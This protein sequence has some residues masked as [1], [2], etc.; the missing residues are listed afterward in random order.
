MKHDLNRAIELVFCLGILA[1]VDFCE[2][3]EPTLAGSV[4][5]VE[6]CVGVW[7]DPASSESR[8]PARIR[9]QVLAAYDRAGS[10]GKR[11]GRRGLFEVHSPGTVLYQERTMGR[12]LVVLVLALALALAGVGGAA[13][14]ACDGGFEYASVNTGA[15]TGLTE[16]TFV[17]IASDCAVAHAPHECGCDPGCAGF[18]AVATGLAQGSVTEVSHAALAAGD[19]LCSS[20]QGSVLSGIRADVWPRGS[21]VGR[22]FTYAAPRGGGTRPTCD[23]AA[24]AQGATV[25][26]RRLSVTGAVVESTLVLAPYGVTEGSSSLRGVDAAVEVLGIE[27]DSP[28]LVSCYLAPDRTDAVTLLPLTGAPLFG[29][30]SGVAVAAQVLCGPNNVGNL[31][32]LLNPKLKRNQCAQAD[33]L[34]CVLNT[35]TALARVS[36]TGNQYRGPPIQLRSNR[37]R[38]CLAFMTAGDG[39]GQ[40]GTVATPKARF[41]S[42]FVLPVNVSYIAM[43]SAGPDP[44]TC[45]LQSPTGVLRAIVTSGASPTVKGAFAEIPGF[46]RPGVRFKFEEFST[47]DC[48]LPVS[49]VVNALPESNEIALPGLQADALWDR[50]RASECGAASPSPSASASASASPS[51]EPNTSPVESDG[52]GDDAIP[53]VLIGGVAGGCGL[54]ALGG[55]LLLSRRASGKSHSGVLGAVGRKNGNADNGNNNGNAD[56]AVGVEVPQLAKL[57]AI[58]IADAVPLASLRAENPEMDS[59]DADEVDMDDDSNGDSC[60]SSAIGGRPTVVESDSFEYVARNT[61]LEL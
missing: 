17:A 55:L 46:E 1:R 58:P 45:Q 56:M 49:V 51:S 41:A 19:W 36:S 27:S 29:W 2:P 4:G 33:G 44:V 16:S 37:P 34:N 13:G 54:L 6:G 53:L 40:G 15:A 31:E 28:V 38:T 8:F 48:D 26:V 43:V 35:T 52:D 47:L 25:T 20:C 12:A 21:D 18:A 59:D 42:Y 24:L 14:E 61:N 23:V 60:H 11:S 3:R 9:R 7:R 5:W 39:D 30:S 32:L 57:F 22:R 10:A 50:F